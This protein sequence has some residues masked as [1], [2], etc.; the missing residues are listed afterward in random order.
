MICENCGKEAV[1]IHVKPDGTEEV[2][3]ESPTTDDP[4][5]RWCG[6]CLSTLDEKR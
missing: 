3:R 5:R 4:D 6:Q 1:Y 2:K